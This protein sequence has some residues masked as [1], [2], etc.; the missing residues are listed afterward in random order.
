MR[1]FESIIEE[2]LG[3]HIIDRLH[4]EVPPDEFRSLVADVAARRLDKSEA[5]DRLLERIIG[6]R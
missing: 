1:R 2:M 4:Q 6:A 5:V 3:D